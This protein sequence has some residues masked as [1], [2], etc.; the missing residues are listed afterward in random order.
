M[1]IDVMTD[2]ALE[3]WSILQLGEKNTL[4]LILTSLPGQ[5]QEIHSSERKSDHDV[6][7]EH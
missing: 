1:L 7:Q 6:I 5:F 4:D 3:K 2:H